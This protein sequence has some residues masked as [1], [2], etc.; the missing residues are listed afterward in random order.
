MNR[1]PFVVDSD[2]T[3]GDSVVGGQAVEAFLSRSLISKCFGQGIILSE[4]QAQQIWIFILIAL[5]HQ[6]VIFLFFNII[7]Q[8]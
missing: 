3:F 4:R 7:N 5:F 6:L 2:R 1:N 8:I